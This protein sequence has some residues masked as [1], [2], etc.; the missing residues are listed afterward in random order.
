MEFVFASS[1]QITA[2]QRA[3]ILELQKECFSH[4]SRKEIQESFIAEGFGWIFAFE[5]Q[6]IVGQ[7]ELH[8]RL[9][10][11]EGVQML[12]GGLGG[13][14]VKTSARRRGIAKELVKTGLDLLRGEKCDVACL[15]AD[16]RN[17]PDGGLYS[18]LGFRIMKR[19]ISFEDVYGGKRYDSGEM[20]IPL[21][22]KEI[23]DLIMNSEKTFHIGRG[24]W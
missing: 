14:C 20:F 4:V 9:V 16:V 6:I 2:H 11:F 3:R 24:Y 18:H 19:R 8:K 23:Y 7:V 15:N 12:L 1:N 10:Q 13:T 21:C 5:N 17:H 22:S